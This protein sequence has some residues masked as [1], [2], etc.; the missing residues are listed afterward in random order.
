MY[1]YFQSINLSSHI[2]FVQSTRGTYV[3]QQN[4][5]GFSTERGPKIFLDSDSADVVFLFET[6]TSERDKMITRVAAH[7]AILAGNSDVFYSMFF[8]TLKETGDIRI[9]DSSGVAFKEFL[10]YFYFIKV[11][12]TESNVVEV[13]YLAEKYNVQ[14]CINDCSKFLMNSINDENACLRLELAI[15]FNQHE[16]ILNST[17]IFKSESFVHCDEMT[18]K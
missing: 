4:C 18:L 8:G 1:Y 14:N 3:N 10:Q 13:L 15:L 12:L 16:I 7:K 9:Q 6:S 5:K 17:A 11:N 2:H